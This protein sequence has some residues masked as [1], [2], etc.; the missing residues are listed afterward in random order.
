MLILN[1]QA[2]TDLAEKETIVL[3]LP[4]GEKVIFHILGRFG[5]NVR[6]GIDAPKNIGISRGTFVHDGCKLN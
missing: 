2:N 5:N 3:D 1:R 6:I 4:N